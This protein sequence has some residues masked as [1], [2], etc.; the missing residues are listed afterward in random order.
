VKLWLIWRALALRARRPEAFAG[1]YTPL[2][3]PPGSVAFL[4][5]DGEVLVAVRVREDAEPFAVPEPER[6]RDVLEGAPGDYGLV[7][8]E[9]ADAVA[10]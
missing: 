10:S 8:L 6:W 3:A 1:A 9:R 4:R 2:D 5:G 7:L